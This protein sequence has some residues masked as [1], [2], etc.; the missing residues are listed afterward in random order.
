[1]FFRRASHW[2]PLVL[3]LSMLSFA[4]A[5]GG[6]DDDV[7]ED[8]PAETAGVPYQSKGNEGTITG[9]VNFSGAAPAPK[10]ID[11]NADAVCSSK[12]PN[13]VA[14]DIVVKDGK[15][16]YAFVYIKSGTTSD[17]K[18]ITG[19]AFPAPG[20][21]AKLDQVGCQYT[22]HV[23]GVQTKQKFLVLNSDTTA[24]NVNVQPNLNPKWNQ[25]QP[26]GAAPIEK[27]FNQAETVI[28]VK[29][30][31]HPWMKAYVAVLRHPFFAV[32]K[33]DGS[34]EIKGVPPGKYTVVV[35]HERWKGEKTMDVTVPDKGTGTADFTLDAGQM[36][37]LVDEIDGGS[38]KVLPALEFPMLAGH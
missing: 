17:N 25:S 31:Q 18:Q 11:M 37:S 13:A 19:F 7:D 16:K 14:E 30:N 12:N 24:H 1:M 21:P 8:A 10:P 2:L 36:A 5:C 15:L 22:P 32:S 9:K 3:I 34:F 23:V 33:E 6:G 20:E 35:W 26:P 27:S 4:L 38:L 28:P 29:C